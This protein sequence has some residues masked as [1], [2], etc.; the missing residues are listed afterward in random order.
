MNQY[1]LL[2]LIVYH[3]QENYSFFKL[4]DDISENFKS[5][6]ESSLTSPSSSFKV[7]EQFANI[8]HEFGNL[9]AHMVGI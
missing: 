8:E 2:Y 4:V 1:Y 3:F 9:K 7:S 6:P 5:H